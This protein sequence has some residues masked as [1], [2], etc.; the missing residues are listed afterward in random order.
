MLRATIAGLGSLLLL[1][2]SPATGG[3][4]GDGP[5][6]FARDVRPILSN[7]CFACH[8]PD[9][10]ARKADLRLDTFED[11]TKDRGGYAAIVAGDAG[12]SEV[13]VRVLGADGTDVMPPEGHGKALTERQVDTLR[14]WIDGG[15]AYEKHWAYV[16]PVPVE[17]PEPAFDGFARNDVDAFTSVAM[18][19][20]GLQP[21]REASRTTLVRR[22]CLTLWGLPAPIDLL[23]RVVADPREDWYDR[24]LDELFESPRH[25]EQ[26][27]RL[28]L[29]AARYGDTHGLHLDNERSIWPYRDW[30]IDAFRR[31]LPYD[32]FV[33]DQLAGDLLP[34][35][36]RDQLVA[37]GFNRCNPTTAEGG[38]IDEE[39]LAKYAF[40]RVDTTSTVFLGLTMGCAKCHDH[41]FDPLTMD[42]Y[43]AMFS[44]FDDMEGKASDEN[45]MV[46]GPV[47]AVPSAEQERELDELAARVDAL[48]AELEGPN[49]EWDR[50]QVEW[51][52]EWR[53]KD[54]EIWRAVAIEAPTADP[55]VEFVPREDG[56]LEAQGPQGDFGDYVLPFAWGTD[57]PATAPLR[58]VRLDVLPGGE[59]GK[60]GRSEHGNIA[61][62]AAILERRDGEGW[63]RVPIARVD[64]DY[65]QPDYEARGLL[66]DDP[67]SAWAVQGGVDD[68]RSV[69][70][71]L[72]EQ[73][74]LGEYRLTLDL[75]SDHRQHFPSAVRLAATSSSL[76]APIEFGT[77]AQAGPVRDPDGGHPFARDLGPDPGGADDGLAWTPIEL[78]EGERRD[79]DGDRSA[80]YLRRTLEVAEPVRVRLAFGSDDGLAVWLDGTSVLSRDVARAYAPRQDEVALELGPG[81]HEFLCKVVNQLGGFAFGFETLEVR[82]GLPSESIAAVLRRE[83]SSRDDDDRALLRTAYRSSESP[84]WAERNRELGA[85][86]ERRT[87]LDD[88]LPRTLIAR[89]RAMPVETHVLLRGQYDH[90]GAV[91]ASA[92]PAALGSLP[93]GVKAD[94]LALARWLV[95]PANPLTA[96]VAANRLWQVCFGRG[97]VETPEDFG[98]QGAW[99]THP[100][101]LDHLA[102]ELVA[103]G[104][105]QRAL[106]REILSSATWRQ[107][108]SAPDSAWRADPGNRWLARGPRYRVDAEV[109]RDT[110]LFASGL[111]VERVGGPSVKP[112]QPAGLWRAVAY[113]SSNTADFV[114]GDGED[115]YRRS[116]YTFVKRTSPQ[117]SM[118]ILDAPDR[119]ICVVRRERTNTPLQALVLLNDVQF[120]EAARALAMRCTAETDGGDAAAITRMFRLVVARLPQD[121]ELGVLL[122]LVRDARAEYA[123]DGAAASALLSVGE[124]AA[125][126]GADAAGLAAL[127]LAASTVLNLDEAQVVR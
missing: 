45:S 121:D 107:D 15:A 50:G 103:S 17:V 28:W 91:V 120:V 117:P 39:Y 22:L 37:T 13:V 16:A 89:D 108:S 52:R 2:G 38:L 44:F 126:M 51:E 119:E 61:I 80:V 74:P 67:R 41:K 78:R 65:E 55:P 9:A 98:V 123:E 19:E 76:V 99:P 71:V 66:D 125:P 32:E 111:L 95:D 6:R 33:V 83:A 27:A 122:G 88:A 21:R 77:W 104:F 26:M 105:D 79:F 18:A 109:L 25:G 54:A 42:D 20:H 113:P 3:N 85:L 1:L 10:A 23:D 92:V 8:G 102:L 5:V 110:A 84:E 60:V 75:H 31:N 58:A 53:A 35:P 36:T 118:S 29:D 100:E 46:P 86:E 49:K 106:L 12:A 115:L 40:D 116:M 82:G 90:P 93:A 48:R 69:R 81:P 4:G 73:A 63:V 72:A 87:A 24:L 43:Y 94:R 64:A 30:V 11:A 96:R 124:S 97:L 56:A 62:S 14:R 70:L 68:V 127:T 114:R 47:L 57:D 34:E 7:H 59:F 101:L 112:Y